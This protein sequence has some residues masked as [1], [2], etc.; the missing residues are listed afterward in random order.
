LFQRGLPE[1]FLREIKGVNMKKLFQKIKNIIDKDIKEEKYK[2]TDDPIFGKIAKQKAP[3]FWVRTTCGYCGVGCGMYIGIKDG[4]GV[5][6]KG[7][8]KHPVNM[9]TL[10][11]KGL[12]E[13]KMVQAPN[14]AK[15]ALI[16]KDGALIEVSWDEAFS[17]VSK[18]FKKI[19]EK[20]GKEAIGVISTGQLLTEEFYALGKFVQLGLRTN[21]YDG[22][23]TLCMASAVMGYKQSFGSDGPVGCYEDLAKAEVV[24][25]IGANIA[26]NHPIL[27]LHLSK[28]RK[29]KKI[30][31]IDPRK[32]KTAQMADI[33]LPI[34][35]RTDLALINGLCYIIFEQGW[36]NESYIKAK[37]TGY[38]E[39]KKHILKNYP[40]QEVA[41]ITG[42]DVKTLYEVAKLYALSNASTI[43]WT[44]GV[45]QSSIG[46][47]TV[48][49]INNLALI[50][51][52]IGKEGAAPFSI[53][54]Q[55]NAMGTRE[56]GFTSSI[57]GY[58][59]FKNQQDRAEFAKII[60]VKEELIPK[61]RGYAYPQI[62]E[63]INKGEIK[64]LWVVATNPLVSYP[65]QKKLREAL[66]KLD[67]L[68][69]QDSFLSDTAQIADVVFGAAT[70]SEKEGT[71]TNSERRCNLA[72]KAKEPYGNTKSDFEI[73]KEFSKYFG[74]HDKL[75]KNLNTPRDVF[76]EI[77]KVS[78]GRFCD[79]SKM[80]YELIQELGGVQWP[81]N[82]KN[83]KGTKRLYTKD[84]PFN[85]SDGKAKLL[86]LDWVSLNEDI[87]KDFPLILNT[88]R[89]VEHFHTRTKT[90][91]IDILNNL[92]P[93]AWVEINSADAKKLKVKSGDL[94]SISSKRGKVSD[95]VVKVTQTI[96]EGTIFVPFHFNKQLV[97]LLTIDE[98][99]SKSFEPNFKQCA[100]QLHSAKVPEGIKLWQKEISAYLQMSKNINKDKINTK[101]YLQK[102]I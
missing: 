94:I 22:N 36:E 59:D 12:S 72:K 102:N 75:F 1:I 31:V 5:Y 26:E 47:D 76:E 46:T 25:L 39:F 78:R 18:K 45:N 42:I 54:G 73:V 87:N 29:N 13:H 49:S 79:Y 2:L 11:P 83:P 71:Y 41:N 66:K 67:L 57:P 50:T 17:K 6:S 85:F 97:N 16:R 38:L 40:P 56:F 7:D 10:C 92:A 33:Y 20:Y 63:A 4:K 9:G 28:N 48:S 55:C 19:Q 98:F 93:R 69:V 30:I 101:K 58:R 96:K 37:T 64:A 14:R 8:P 21:N 77:K 34:K 23:T 74:V 82:E 32:S 60:G 81:C 44:M 43:A 27:K 35:P 99:D 95:I 52:Q 65:N 89:C 80:S 53:T 3:D 61:Q 90:G 84:M 86:P 68:V 70:W 88:G 15:G 51:G 100:V 91:N 62:I 24:I